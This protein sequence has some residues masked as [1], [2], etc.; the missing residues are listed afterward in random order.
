M[1]G[2]RFKMISFISLWVKEIITVLIIVIML[3]IIIP[4]THNKKFIKLVMGLFVLYT[5]VKPIVSSKVRNFSFSNSI[6]VS[7]LNV[8]NYSNSNIV[9]DSN[10]EDVYKV[11]LKENIEGGLSQKGYECQIVD[12]QIE[13]ADGRFG[14]IKQIELNVSKKESNDVNEIKIEEV[15][16]EKEKVMNSLNEEKIEEVKEFLSSTFG[17]SKEN[18][19]IGGDKNKRG[20]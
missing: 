12:L 18:I 1:K 17:V 11:K 7:S 6:N 8:Q 14:E 9:S 10:I 3:D 19:I 15:N 4:E 5:I 2:M 16:L 20:V 13:T